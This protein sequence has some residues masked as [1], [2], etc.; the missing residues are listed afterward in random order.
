MA[1]AGARAARWWQALWGDD[2]LLLSLP[3]VG[4]TVAPT[5]RAFLGDGSRFATAKHATSF[6][7]VTPSNWSSGT[8]TQ[9]SRAITKEGPAALRLAFYQA[10]NAARA[11]DPQ[12]A[13]FYRTLMVERGHCHAQATIAVARKLIARTW[14]TITRGTPYELRDLDGARVTRR[15][16]STLARSLRVPADV[17]RRSRAHTTA[18]KRGRLTR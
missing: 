2:D 15:Q 8:V 18:V 14:R 4:P 1:G 11:V 9:P 17:R 7:G 12:L 3:G 10:A 13:G 5:I 16:A 6:V